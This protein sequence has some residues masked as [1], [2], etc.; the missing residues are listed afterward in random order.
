MDDLTKQH[1]CSLEV[2]ISLFCWIRFFLL[3]TQNYSIT[4]NFTLNLSPQFTLDFTAQ[5]NFQLNR[6]NDLI[7]PLGNFRRIVR[8]INE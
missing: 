1:N 8:T 6:K 4:I 7:C 2:I 3:V 5:N